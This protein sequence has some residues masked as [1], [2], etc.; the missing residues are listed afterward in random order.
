MTHTPGPWTACNGQSLTI[1]DDEVVVPNHVKRVFVAP[2]GRRCSQF[3][4][5]CNLQL[6]ES[7]ANARLIAAAPELLSA[8]KELFEDYKLLVNSGDIVA[9]SI[10]NTG[11]GQQTLEVIAKAEGR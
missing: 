3:I 7:T 11:I 1:N 5:A 2:D 6:D 4:C 8:L 10:E 9:W